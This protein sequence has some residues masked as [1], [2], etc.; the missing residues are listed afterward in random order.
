VHKLTLVVAF[1]LVLAAPA[2]GDPVV[3]NGPLTLTNA[4]ARVEQAGFDVR[5]ARADAEAAQARAGLARA[6]IGPRVGASANYLN[7]NLPQ[8]G[9][10]V[11]RQTYFSLTA[12]VPI[13]VPHDWLAARSA[14][15]QA[16]ASSADAQMLRADSVLAVIALYHRVQLSNALVSARETTLSYQNENL[17]LTRE[18]VTAGKSPRYLIARDLS[19]AANAEQALEDARSQRD[20]AVNDL[21]MALDYD[22]SSNITLVQPLAEERPP[23]LDEKT[24]LGRAAVQRPDVLAAIGRLQ[25]ASA[26]V[27]SARASYFPDLTATAQTYNGNSTPPLG[28][29]GSQVGI[30]ASI[31]LIDTGSRAAQYREAR[32]GL[33]RAQAEL[34][35]L[36]LGAQRDVLNALREVQAALMELRSARAAITDAEIERRIATLRQTAGKGIYLEVLDAVSLS[37]QA[38]ESELQALSRLDD[39]IAALHHAAGDPL[40]WQ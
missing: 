12:S 19:G 16:S 13:F 7:A 20:Q 22:M 32:A 15:L 14:R 9:M 23:L 18:R 25:A 28:T 2:A 27:A 11:A 35:K 36:K 33:E 39:A 8:F 5:I 26:S 40:P 31:P 37:A 21:K 29:R 34:D 4:V 1:L 6:V 10:P 30:S 38:R 3:F 24:W 17:Q